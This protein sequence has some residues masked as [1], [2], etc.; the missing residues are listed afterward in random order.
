MPALG[1]LGRQLPDERIDLVLVLPRVRRDLRDGEPLGHRAQ[2]RGPESRTRPPVAE[3]DRVP[4]TQNF[5]PAQLAAF[6]PA[7]VGL[8]LCVAVVQIRMDDPWANGVLAV[9]AAVP[10]IVLLYLGLEA[11]NGDGAPRA[12]VTIFL[13]AGLVLAGVAIARLGNAL[14]GD[15][16]TA[17]GGTLTWMLAAF[18]ALAAFCASKARSAACLLIAA[19]AAV[20]L[21]METVNWIF[22]AEDFD[23]FRVLLA[24]SFVA[25][26]AAGVAVAGRSGTILVAAAGVTV[27][28]GSFGTGVG[29]LFFGS[30]SGLGWGWELVTLVEGVVLVAYA[31]QRLEPGPGYLAFF[32]LALFVQTAA[33]V[34][35]DEGVVFLDEAQ[36]PPDSSLVGWPLALAVGTVAAVLWGLRQTASER[37]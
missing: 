16:F 11:A 30:A 33:A 22:D 14:G 25:L 6:A 2:L 23:T 21:L 17:G 18:T 12:A 1:E 9:V 4:T 8:A 37:R 15:D 36:Q 34:G 20:G 10:A 27:L 5:R 24:L 13:V 3:S 7:A 32:V 31:A 28:A 19:L 26:F 29:L 35:G